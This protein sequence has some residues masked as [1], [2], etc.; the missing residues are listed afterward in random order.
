LKLVKLRDSCNFL[1]EVCDSDCA[2]VVREQYRIIDARWRDVLVALVDQ[3]AKDFDAGLDE[4]NQWCD[5]VIANLWGSTGPTHESFCQ[6][7]N[8]LQVITLFVVFLF[9]H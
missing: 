2:A 1:V 6:Q 8:F 9:V 4:I 5:M 7:I 3:S